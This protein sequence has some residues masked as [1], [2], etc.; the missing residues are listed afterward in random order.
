MLNDLQ[1]EL[2]KLF[3]FEWDYSPIY[4][5]KH[6]SFNS[7]KGQAYTNI[8]LWSE[9]FGLGGV[10]NHF[11]EDKDGVVIIQYAMCKQIR[12]SG[13]PLP[14]PFQLLQNC[15]HHYY[16]LLLSCL[17]VL[18]GKPVKRVMLRDCYNGRDI[19][20]KYNPTFA[21]KFLAH[22]L[23]TDRVMA[24]GPRQSQPQFSLF[25]S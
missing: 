17:G 25:N 20:I 6:D 1:R 13:D 18:S 10:A 11:H 23:T 2:N 5:E 9:E 21:K 8:E 15:E 3:T 24:S 19:F 16:G 7:I 22:V 4:K 14:A 12:T